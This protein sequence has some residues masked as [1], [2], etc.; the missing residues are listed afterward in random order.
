MVLL[1]EVVAFGGMP[2]YNQYS[3]HSSNRAI[4]S[5]ENAYFS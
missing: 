2:F 4:L 1:Q 3:N 5:S